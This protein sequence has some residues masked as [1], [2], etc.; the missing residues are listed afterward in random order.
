MF[1]IKGLLYGLTLAVSFGPAY[2]T[3]M[4][5]TMRRGLSGGFSVAAGI[6]ITDLLMMVAAFE[7][8]SLLL[9]SLTH[10]SLFVIISGL[11][12]FAYG[13]YSILKPNKVNIDEKSSD[14]TI[15]PKPLLLIL[16]GAI[17]NLGNP[18]NAVFWAGLAGMALGAGASSS[19]SRVST[20]GGILFMATITTVLKCYL[21]LWISKK[22][23]PRLVIRVQQLTGSLIMVAGLWLVF[24]ALIA[25]LN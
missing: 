19:I 8:F 14:T 18:F 2:M 13:L 12:L 25:S 20:M 24:S 17:I 11:I 21:A 7:G 10:E 15:S 5:V 23:S 9:K 22:T 3:M 4:Q 1:F 6:L 16:K